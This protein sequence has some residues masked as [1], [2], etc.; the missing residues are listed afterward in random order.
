MAYQ[1]GRHVIGFEVQKVLAAVDWLELNN[2]DGPGIAVAGYG[3][4]GLI[5]L[6]SAA[7]D[8][9]IESCLVSGYFGPRE[10]LWREP[11]YRNAWALLL[12][13]GDA[14]IASLVFPR[15]LVIE[16][17]R[18]PD[19]S[20]PP[21][22]TEEQRSA[23]A[24]GKILT[25]APQELSNEYLRLTEWAEPFPQTLNCK[26]RLVPEDPASGPVPFGSEEALQHLLD[27][28]L[29]QPVSFRH[30][31]R[32]V[33]ETRVRK[34]VIR[35]RQ[36]RQVR[37]LERAIQRFLKDSSDER[38]EFFLKTMPN[39]S[40]EEFTAAATPFREYLWKQVIGKIEEPLLPMNPRSRKWGE[41]KNWT[42]YEVALD[43]WPDVFAWGI[44][45]VPKELSAG[46]KRPVVVAQHGLEGLPEDVVRTDV[47]GFR[48]YQAF[49]SKLADQGYVVFAPHNPYR[50]GDRFRVLQR[51]GNPL[52]LSLFS[53][54]I[55]QHQQILNWLKTLPFVDARRIGFYGL[56]Y[57]GKTAITVPAI[58]EDY[59]LSICSGNFNEWIW[60]NVTVDWAN[61]YMYT[62]EYEMPDFGSGVTFGHAEMA[63]LIFPRPFMVERG[64]QDDVGL[65]EWVA[66]EYSKVRRLYKQLGHGD[67]TRIEFFNGGHEIHGEGTFEFLSHLLNWKDLGSR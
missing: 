4:G 46:E 1:M 40:P 19:I 25:P 16:Y 62:G 67:R 28:F 44:L 15:N 22:P 45:L 57:G 12:E 24:P 54:I 51:K 10:S 20:G 59:A 49:A 48:L 53:F 29:S 58:L 3:E 64:H 43:V 23:A 31:N 9:R 36:R 66:Y 32:G 7:L 18:V 27:P 50:G 11:I 8:Q 42:G 65:D 21:E 17:S 14:E 35:E 39:H 30:G 47:Q 60:K 37:Q 61:S 26:P 41:G 63:Y 52:K 5:S 56:S 6:Y 34:E 55:G 33:A 2:S 13:F 38:E